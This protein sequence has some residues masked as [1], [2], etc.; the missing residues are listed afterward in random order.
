MP[1]IAESSGRTGEKKK[2]RGGTVEG[3]K[4]GWDGVSEGEKLRN[5]TKR[6]G[7][8]GGGVGMVGI[9]YY[10]KLLCGKEMSICNSNQLRFKTM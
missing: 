1:T 2:G 4:K 6:F 7:E 10:Q 3:K 5:N 8:G 9:F